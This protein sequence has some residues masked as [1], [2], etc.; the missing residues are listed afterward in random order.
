MA[1]ARWTPP[2][3]RSSEQAR[4]AQSSEMCSSL[5]PVEWSVK[6]PGR[7]C[8]SVSGRTILTAEALAWRVFHE[9]LGHVANVHG[10]AVGNM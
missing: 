3:P 4:Q 10:R 5:T 9:G 7:V 1:A 8:L 2:L 6:G